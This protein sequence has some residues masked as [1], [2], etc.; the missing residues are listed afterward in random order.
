MRCAIGNK[1]V[2]MIRFLL[3][4]L[5]LSLPVTALSASEKKG[6]SVENPRAFPTVTVQKNGAVFLTIDNNGDTGDKLV[7]ARA[8]VSERVEL[9]THIMDGDVMMM[10][11]VEFYD[12]PAHSVV[13]L[14]PAGHHIM[15]INLHKALEPGFSFPLTL[16][17]EKAGDLTVNV[18]VAKL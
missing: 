17:F 13:K 16:H 6:L 9:H 1:D 8:D 18:D 5:V 12:I 10:R 3:I 15:L 2:F 11:E 14:E 4:L 7:S